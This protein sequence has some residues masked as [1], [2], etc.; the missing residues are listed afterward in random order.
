MQS[1][2]HHHF[3][4][5]HKCTLFLGHNTLASS[6]ARLYMDVVNIYM[7]MYIYIYIWVYACKY[8]YREKVSEW[9]KK[10]RGCLPLNLPIREKVSEREKKSQNDVGLRQTPLQRPRVSTF[11]TKVH[12]E[13]WCGSGLDWTI[14]IVPTRPPPTYHAL[15]FF[16]FLGGR[17]KCPKKHYVLWVTT[18]IL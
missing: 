4:S 16:N 17:G 5:H 14:F 15:V 6:V 12:I 8:T 1:Q 13:L 7:Y 3:Y 2:T 9:E 10:W 18:Q 11:H